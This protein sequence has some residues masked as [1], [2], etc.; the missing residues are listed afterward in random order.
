MSETGSSEAG[1]SEVEPIKVEPTEV[2]PTEVESSD[3]G[4]P[5]VGKPGEGALPERPTVRPRNRRRLRRVVVTSLIAVVLVL[6]V[7]AAGTGLYVNSIKLPSL[8]DFPS[9]TVLY[10]SDGTVM[11]HLGENRR[12]EVPAE[13]ILREVQ[14]VAVAAED[15]D[16]YSDAGGPIARSVTRG[17]FDIAGDT[18]STRL[19]VAVM[20]RK[21]EDTYGKDR[22]L[23][24]YLN[25]SLFG[26]LTYGIEAAAREYF[27]KTVD[28]RVT[29]VPRLTTAEAMVLVA[30]LRQPEPDVTD[31][32]GLPGYDPT[33]GSVAAQNSRNRFNEI[34]ASLVDLGYLTD[35]QAK[36]LT[37]PTNV[38]PYDEKARVDEMSRPVGQVVNHVLS[39][40]T[41]SESSPWRGKTWRSIRD[42]GYQIYTTIDARAQA[43]IEASADAK[44]SGS[45]MAGQ[46][47]NLQAAAVLVEPGTGR[48]LGYFGGSDGR[49]SD[50]AG[51]YN[52]EKGD[53][54]G[55]GAHPPGG[56]F[57][58]H[59]LAAALQSGVSLKSNWQWT[60]H[61]MP[62]RTG[63]NQSPNAS[64]CPG[65][66]AKS[67][68]CSLLDST[69][70][71]LNVAYYGLTVSVT[72]A[73]VLEMAR[74]VGIDTMWTDSRERQDLRQ[75]KDMAKLVPSKFD[76]VLGL[77]QYPVTVLDQANAMA[78]YAAGGLRAQAHFVYHVRQGDHVI[79]GESLPR[80]DQPRALG[81]SALAD[82][83]YALSRGVTGK[84]TG[85]D[86]ASKPGAWEYANRVD[87]NTNAWMVGYTGNLAMAVWVGNSKQ[88]QAIKDAAGRT[89]WGPGLPA[90]I[91][92]DVMNSVHTSMNRKPVAFP[93]PVFGGTVNPPG[94]VPS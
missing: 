13:H 19:R 12:T 81:G 58:V 77:G 33:R 79:F 9:N 29:N 63:A 78:T 4:S 37:Y 36:S 7:G 10:Y 26:R 57:Q 35:E 51:V 8:L 56:T 72:P 14:Q 52:D 68:N 88:E 20:A 93:A 70:A 86:S 84:V 74:A 17:S 23:G 82:L 67:G 69:E 44:A 92:R 76:T 91:Y 60:P 38:K 45:A 94:S 31:P 65:D 89:I 59:T 49:G 28:S 48:V 18:T 32:Q 22:V 41:S 34:S 46:P 5:E 30:M 66:P 55:F 80:P 24:L 25:D 64:T 6:G 16:F 43:A 50:F 3:V 71:S 85:R 42:G 61:D 87:Q 11:A 90:T 27:G 21:L 62:G 75:V 1:S 53:G 73:K 83:D 2:E 15:P 54:V 47:P 40:L 39:E